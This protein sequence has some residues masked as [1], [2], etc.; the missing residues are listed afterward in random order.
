ME[1]DYNEILCEAIDVIVKNR[2]SA[3][4]FDKSIICTIVDDNE[5]TKGHYI[6]TDGTIKFDAYTES[7]KYKVND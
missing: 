1:K 3:V 7:E 4:S 6:V 5:K 2:L